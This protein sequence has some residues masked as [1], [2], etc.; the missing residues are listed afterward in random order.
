[1]LSLLRYIVTLT[2][3]TVLCLFDVS[4]LC[5]F[6][7]QS[8]HPFDMLTVDDI[9]DTYG[10]SHYIHTDRVTIQYIYTYT[11]HTLTTNNHNVM[12]YRLTDTVGYLPSS[13]GASPSGN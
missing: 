13:K 1:M 6:N 9:Y 2:A 4:V 10:H 12:N 3:I 11:V 7:V 5:Y 8:N